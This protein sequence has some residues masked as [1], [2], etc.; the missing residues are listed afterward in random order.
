MKTIRV[1]HAHNHGH[2][3]IGDDAM[4]N[5]VYR[6]LAAR[7]D[8][9]WTITTYSPPSGAY[10][11][12]DIK[13]LSGIINNYENLLVK[14]ALVLISR[15][16]LKS[17]YAAYSYIFCETVYRLAC[18]RKA[19]LPT[20]AFGKVKKTIHALSECKSYVRS[21]SGSL[22]DIWFWSS[23]Y[24]QY[25]E[26]R[27]AHLFDAD[28]YFLGQGIGP[29]T[30]NYRIKVLGKFS[31][32]CTLITLRDHENSSALLATSN[33]DRVNWVTVGDDA[34]DYP[35]EPLP[36][37][38]SR[39]L[40]N[41]K[42]IL[43][44]FRTTNYEKSLRHEFWND[45]ANNLKEIASTYPEYT[46]VAISF[47]SGKVNDLAAAREIN[48]VANMQLLKI[49]ECELTPGQAKALLASAKFSIG[50]S[51][52]FGVFSLAENTPF[53]GIYTNDYYKD[54]LVGLLEW[55]DYA[56]CAIP[57]VKLKEMVSAADQIMGNTKIMQEHIKAINESLT[58]KINSV[59]DRI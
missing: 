31:N 53:I 44:Q 22:N 28:V 47:S 9:V 50:Q 18:L 57:S 51:Y 10:T 6:K 25:T 58:E 1:L 30:S 11:N 5:N 17:L 4:A 7:F 12:R 37:S 55:Y 16:K 39:E 52:H 34:I 43:C 20:L 3:N 2:K 14:I 24:P 59:F 49:I 48:R 36:V 54:K 23:M 27:I 35:T 40:G 46:L 29:L 8:D 32:A 19:G 56:F 38:V 42:Y 45:L 41:G 33:A 21:G 26:A 15:L 13:S